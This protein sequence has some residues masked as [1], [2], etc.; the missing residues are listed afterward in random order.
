MNMKGQA[1]LITL[2]VMAIAVT[3]ILSVAS[4]SVT[5]V[6]LSSKEDEAARAFS[7]A[8]AGI[9]EGLITGLGA[10]APSGSFQNG[11]M[12]SATL[13]AIGSGSQ[14]IYPQDVQTG[15]SATIWLVAHDPNGNIICDNKNACFTGRTFTVCW[16][17]PISPSETLPAV[18]IA[19]FWTD[20][21]GTPFVSRGAYD[22]DSTRRQ[23]NKFDPVDSGGCTIVDKTFPYQKSID[24]S[25]LG[26]T[27]RNRSSDLNPG[28]QFIK[29]RPVY[30][31]GPQS[32][33]VQV[34]ES[35]LPA[36]GKLITSLGSSGGANRKIQVTQ[37]FP[38]PPSI[39]DFA[40]FSPNSI[41]KAAPD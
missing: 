29:V 24:L 5:E 20:N 15:D 25:N 40:V 41:Q 18:E 10:P 4:R 36:Q 26:V 34:S 23:V 12:Y 2:L 27:Q 14:Y 28:P 16:G 13:T 33:G 11:A 1:L 37:L 32:V 19:I 39:F 3:V 6:G 38:A 30:N 7:A 21:N 31:A 9:E 17:K 35:S 22:P 8:E